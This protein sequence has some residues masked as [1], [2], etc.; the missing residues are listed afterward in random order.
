MGSSC[1]VFS[2]SSFILQ[3]R[4]SEE[5]DSSSIHNIYSNFLEANLEQL[6]LATD[7]AEFVFN[8]VVFILTIYRTSTLVYQARKAGIQHSLSVIARW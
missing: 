1:L 6:Q 3:S 8:L 2:K 5:I 4:S 7:I